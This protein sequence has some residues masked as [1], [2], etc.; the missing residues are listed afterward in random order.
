MRHR[1]DGNSGFLLLDLHAD[2]FPV[3]C[4]LPFLSSGLWRSVVAPSPLRLGQSDPVFTRPYLGSWGQSLLIWDSQARILDSLVH[5]PPQESLSGSPLPS[6][7][8]SFGGGPSD[9][10]SLLCSSHSMSKYCLLQG[11]ASS[12]LELRV[13]AGATHCRHC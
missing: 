10:A 6:P 13:S 4:H 11:P 1:D 9:F 5:Q 3:H 8:L 7:M 2:F 12:F